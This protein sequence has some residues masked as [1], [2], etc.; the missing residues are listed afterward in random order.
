VSSVAALAAFAL[1]LAL[2]V[3]LYLAGQQGEIDGVQVAAIA[4]V[5]FGLIA[6]L[7]SLALL[8][9]RDPLVL[10]ETGRQ[11][12]V[13]AA[14]AVGAL[15]FAHLYVCRP[16]WFGGMLRQYWP[17]IVMGIAFAGVGA[18]EFFARRNVRVLA[19]PLMRT[20]ALLPLLPVLGWWVV[21]SQADYALLLLVVGILYLALS[22]AR[23]S[24]AAMVAATVAGNG[25]LW[26]LLADTNLR[27]LTHPQLW[28]IPPALSVLIAAQLNRR[29]LAPEALATIR[30]A[31]ASVIYVS[32]TSEIF[33]GSMSSSIVAPMVLLG[34]AV[35]GALAGI[36]LQVR[37]FLILGSAFTLMAL[38][39]MVRHAA[40]SIGEVWPWWVFGIA[41]GV[42][43]LVLF[44]VFEKK[45]DEV[46]LLIARLK[47][48]ER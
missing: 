43:L 10:S 40:R 38:I 46:S 44:G 3:Q 19:E 42:G 30:Y 5:L 23:R 41:L 20:G 39:A 32:S 31:A 47:Q 1:T 45:R 15:L 17:F 26:A 9:G 13:Y 24:W 8:P 37:A 2:E 34:L 4:V 48:W 35:V 33:T 18:A 7:V 12:Y 11:G 29:R 28:M 27:F 21:G 22:Y 36:A 25:A 14:E 6:G 16:E